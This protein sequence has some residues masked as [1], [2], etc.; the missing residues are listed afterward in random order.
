MDV[1]LVHHTK[2][3]QSGTAIAF[4][5]ITILG[6]AIQDIASVGSFLQVPFGNTFVTNLAKILQINEQIRRMYIYLLFCFFV[7][8]FKLRCAILIVIY[9]TIFIIIVGI[10]RVFFFL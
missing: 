8:N 2:L 3:D 9:I 10:N 6:T 1:R 5:G 7:F 4:H